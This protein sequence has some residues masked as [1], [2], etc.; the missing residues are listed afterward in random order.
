MKQFIYTIL[1]VTILLIFKT[2][3]IDTGLNVMKREG[4]I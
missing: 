3:H 1:I 4:Y 2:S